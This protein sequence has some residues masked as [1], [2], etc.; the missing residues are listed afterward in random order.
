MSQVKRRIGAGRRS[1]LGTMLDGLRAAEPGLLFDL[2]DLRRRPRH[3]N[4]AVIRRLCV[5]AYLGDSSA[6]CR[7]LGRYKMFVDTGDIGLSTHLLIDGYWEMWVT[8]AMLGFVRAAMVAI[9]VGANLGYFTLLLADLV[10]RE[11]RVHAFEPNPTIMQRLARSVTVN[12]FGSRTT[13]HAAPL[14]AEV[15]EQVRLVVPENEPKNA[16]ILPEDRAA[17]FGVPLLTTTIDEVVGDGP[18]DFIKIDAEGA[19]LA[20]WHGMRRLLARGRPL[21]IFLE[22]NPARYADAAGFLAEIQAQGF[23]MAVIDPQAGVVP[24][25]AATVL[26]SQS[27]EDWMLVLAR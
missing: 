16:H 12:G 13:L 7:V 20:I 3:L 5:N 11:G 22:F 25:A 18:V 19:E 17:G 10:G 24:V 21:T 14:S 23:A 15:G 9:D 26:A 6:L 27:G 1:P 4:E 2:G 8:E